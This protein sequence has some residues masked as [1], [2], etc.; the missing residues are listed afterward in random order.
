MKWQNGKAKMSALARS[1]VMSRRPNVV[2]VGAPRPSIARVEREGHGNVVGN[3]G[4]N[5]NWQD[6]TNKLAALCGGGRFL[7]CG[8][9]SGNCQCGQKGN[10]NGSQ[11]SDMVI[12]NKDGQPCARA[13]WVPVTVTNPAVVAALGQGT[14]T[15]APQ[16]SFKL[17]RL[18]LTAAQAADFTGISI[19]VGPTLNILPSTVDGT[20][21]SVASNQDGDG[22]VDA[23]IC[24][25][26]QLIIITLT[27]TAGVA[28]GAARWTI[29]G[30]YAGQLDPHY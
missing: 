11:T 28:A 18:T 25:P 12:R 5:G 27:P 19:Q 15:F 2:L 7:P 9:N 20:Y 1:D 21:F 4:G 30:A 10:G 16:A 13:R 29:Q 22:R 3:L 24:D 23:P 26:G 14:A 17:A 8:C 6:M